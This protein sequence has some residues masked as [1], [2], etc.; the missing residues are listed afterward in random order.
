MKKKKTPYE[1][2]LKVYWTVTD[3]MNVLGLTNYR[4][5]KRLYDAA[6]QIDSQ[7]EFRAEPKK[8]RRTVVCKLAQIDLRQRQR[9]LK[10]AEAVEEHT[11]VAR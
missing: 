2:S 10:E 4:T 6:D 1:A 11:A 7:Q 9:E 3:I 5:A 8:V